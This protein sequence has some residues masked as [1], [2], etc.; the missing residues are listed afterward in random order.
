M[1]FGFRLRRWG[2]RGVSEGSKAHLQSSP[3]A[4]YNPARESAPK[5]RCFVKDSLKG[6]LR[7][8]YTATETVARP[9]RAHLYIIS[10]FS[11]TTYRTTVKYG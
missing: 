6:R 10:F 4:E 7:H 9:G 8:I 2:G 1:M 11:S 3:P 5:L